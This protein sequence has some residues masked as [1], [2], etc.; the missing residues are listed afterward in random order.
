[1]SQT[2][3]N[4]QLQL[5]KELHEKEQNFGNRADGAGLADRLPVSIHRMHQ[6]GVCNS[7]LDYG[8]GKGKLVHRLRRELPETISVYGYDPAVEEWRKKPS[9][10]VDILVCL[11]V[12]EH[13][14]IKSL[15]KVL[16]EIYEM[17]NVFCYL[18]IDLQ[19]AVKNLS[20][21][22][23]AHILLAPSEW[24]VTRLSQLFPSIASFP[25]MHGKGVPQKVVIAGCKKNNM[26]Q[27]MYSFLMKLNVFSFVMGGGSLG[28]KVK[29]KK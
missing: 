12:L 21:G 14:E 28:G 15:N 24:W 13:V 22:R 26:T 3:S 19:P 9:Q 8:T 16:E 29:G 4:K 5:N 11:D 7:V 10:S 25:V 17:T 23:N 20:D 27:Y 18:V 2:I 1:M 6:M